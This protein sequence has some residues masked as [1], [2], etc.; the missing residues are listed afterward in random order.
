MKAVRGTGSGAAVVDLDS[1]GAFRVAADRTSQA[2]PVV[3]E[4]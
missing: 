2:I 3:I 1:E 4:P